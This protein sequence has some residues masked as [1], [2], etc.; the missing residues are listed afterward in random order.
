MSVVWK[1]L[2][3]IFFSQIH[4][5]KYCSRVWLSELEC[6]EWNGVSKCRN[7]IYFR[8]KT[9]SQYIR[10]IHICPSQKSLLNTKSRIF[11]MIW[12]VKKCEF[13]LFPR[14]HFNFQTARII[15]NQDTFLKNEN[16]I[17][18][19]ENCGHSDPC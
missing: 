13:K 18:K 5:Y 16:N 8:R 4:T 2:S 6:R 7:F 3:D 10:F 15:K 9:T 1:R 19:I 17:F 12:S 14:Q 11:F